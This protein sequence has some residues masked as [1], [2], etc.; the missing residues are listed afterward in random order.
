VMRELIYESLTKQSELLMSGEVSSEA[1]TKAHLEQIERTE[2]EIGAFITLDKV[3]ALRQAKA[4][5]KKRQNG[6]K[7]SVIAGIPM[8]I[9]DNI[10]AVELPTTCASKMLENYYSP[11]DAHVVSL[12]KNADAIIMGKLNMDEFAMGGST[13][14]SYFKK[15]KNPVCTDCVP[16]GSSGG[17]AASVGAHQV[18]YS[19]GSDTGGSIR[20]PASFC[21]VVGLKP[22]YSRISRRGLVAFAS[23]LDQ[24]G[25]I[26]RTVEDVAQIYKVLAVQDLKDSTSGKSETRSVSELLHKEMRQ[27]RIALPTSFFSSGIQKEVKE[28][29]L[30]VA[31]VFESLGALVEEVEI[32]DLDCALPAYYL[33][34][35]AEAS[36]NLARFDGV[37]YGYRTEA[38]ED[39]DSL[40]KKS[41]GEGFGAEVKRRILLGTYALS[42]GYYEAYYQKALKAKAFVSM[43]FDKIFEHY[44]FIISPVTPTTAYHFGDHDQSPVERYLGDI[45]TVPLNLAGLPGISVNCGF[46]ASGLPIG[47]QFI[48]QAYDEQTIL[49]AAY[50][51]EQTKKIWRAMR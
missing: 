51:F 34:S 9:K 17:S 23:S 6:E 43:T 24:I 41:R 11:Y 30:Q 2:S 22:T 39:M 29:I 42:S 18:A 16:G 28:A 45:Y 46:D 13:E 50:A 37:K 12:L 47:V 10:C 1:L 44:D 8:G 14:T 27:L 19:L 36:S 4:V 49:S 3:G 31:K 25:P 33:L 40:Y 32:S 38:F 26:G 15:T 48:G 5:D 7:L 20:Q 21:G 35:S